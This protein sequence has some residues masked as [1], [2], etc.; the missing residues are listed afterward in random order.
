MAMGHP[1]AGQAGVA[2]WL[3]SS[4]EGGSPRAVYLARF[5]HMNHCVVIYQKQRTKRG[6]RF[7]FMIRITPKN[8]HGWTIM[9]TSAASSFNHGGISR[10]GRVNVM[11][12]YISPFH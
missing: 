5:P 6:Y 9:K 2:R 8:Q 1:R 12:T 10:A 4:L 11:R 7:C 3:E